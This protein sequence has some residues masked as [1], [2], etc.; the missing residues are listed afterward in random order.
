MLPTSHEISIPTSG[1]MKT[2]SQP[3]HPTSNTSAR[4]PLSWEKTQRSLVELN[5]NLPS[6][7]LHCPHFAP[8]ELAEATNNRGIRTLTYGAAGSVV[9]GD[10]EMAMTKGND[11]FVKKN[12]C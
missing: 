12:N 7:F 9:T 6:T 8:K 11:W 3:L 5:V 10:W 4:L 2:E 1:Y